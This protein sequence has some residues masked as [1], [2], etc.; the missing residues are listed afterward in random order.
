MA[1][2]AIPQDKINFN[3]PARVKSDIEYL[4]ASFSMN[5]SEFMNTVCAELL[6]KYDGRIK[7]QKTKAKDSANILGDVVPT[8]AAGKSTTSRAAKR[9]SRK[10]KTAADI[11]D[12]NVP[13][14][15][16]APM[17]AGGDGYETT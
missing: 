5:L 3:V 17:K 14:D 12:T 7:E 1:K 9:K 13:D 11:S 6:K 4:A 16:S 2:A 10:P 8:K 15:V